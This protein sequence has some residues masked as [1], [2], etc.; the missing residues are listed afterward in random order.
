MN[1]NYNIEVPDDIYYSLCNLLHLNWNIHHFSSAT[2]LRL[3]SEKS[4]NKSSC[5]GVNYELLIDY[6][7]YRHVDEK[8]KIFSVA[9]IIIPKINEKRK[10]S[11]K[12]NSIL[13]KQL[14][15]TVKNTI[16][17]LCGQTFQEMHRCQKIHGI[18]SF[19]AF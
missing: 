2:F 10:T 8:D 3:L 19:I 9:G 13:E 17:V 14:P 15:N 16:S 1:Q 18:N 11:I 5:Q 6:L 7:P 4:P 12:Q